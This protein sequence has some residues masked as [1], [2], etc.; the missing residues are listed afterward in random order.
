[1]RTVHRILSVFA[2]LFMLYLGL[3]GTLMQMM[4]LK[5]LFSKA[6]DNDIT[7]QSMNEGRW[8][9]GEIAVINKSDLTGTALPKD[10]D[11]R[12]AFTTVLAGLHR[13]MPGLEPRF[14]ELRVANGVTIGQVRVKMPN[15]P[16]PASPWGGDP[17]QKIL[18]FDAK[19]GAAVTATDISN[20]QPPQ[21]VRQVSKQLHR[22]WGG[23]LG[24]DK[25]GVYIE[26]ACGLAMCTLII[27]GLWMYYKLLAGRMKTGRKQVFWMAG[28][29]WKSL[30]RIFSVAAS[31]FLI[32]VAASGTW[33]GFESSWHTFT[34]S[35]PHFDASQPLSDAKVMAML[36]QTQ[37]IVARNKPNVPL[38][39]LRV[40][41]YGG[42]N[43][44]V[45][46][47]GSA[48]I[49][50]IMYNL[51]NGRVATLKEPGYPKSQFPLGTQ[52]HED[53]KHFHS[54]DMFG[55][56]SRFMNLLAGLALIYLSVSGVVMYVEM[57]R[58][59]AKAGRN[60]LIW[61]K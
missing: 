49:D 5:A 41:V 29:T 54:G 35:D 55:L 22:F 40:R 34:H 17:S 9:N 20:I 56:P 46:V 8:G 45:I 61:T 30:H 26:L 21:G 58:K 59:R 33:L 27:T 10:T 44:G 2:I 48:P 47:T 36:D 32:A 37:A 3:T 43:Q 1:M 25:P 11:Y 28:G 4:D 51:D 12:Q 15:A 23:F 42:M 19:T 53:V 24:G 16:P 13:D 52:V 60:A 50:Q 18:A 39:V 6:P 14:V 31:V 57:W 7:L 38:K